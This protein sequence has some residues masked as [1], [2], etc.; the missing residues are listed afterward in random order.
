M[1]KKSLLK[2]KIYNYTNVEHTIKE[3]QNYKQTEKKKENNYT[4]YQIKKD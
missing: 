1:K 4:K 2:T 3:I